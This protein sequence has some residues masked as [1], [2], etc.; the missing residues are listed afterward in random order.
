M[1]LSSIFA[2]EPSP[3]GSPFDVTDPPT[4]PAAMGVTSITGTAP[5]LGSMKSWG[6]PSLPSCHTPYMSSQLLILR[7]GKAVAPLCPPASPL[8]VLGKIMI[9][10]ITIMQML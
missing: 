6:S 8:D 9:Y 2:P 4:H 10:N 1:S 3:D 5:C 7:E